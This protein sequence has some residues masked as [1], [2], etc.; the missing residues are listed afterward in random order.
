MK[1]PENFV[2]LVKITR[3]YKLKCLFDETIGV[4]LHILLDFGRTRPTLWAKMV[5]WACIML[6]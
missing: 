5:T 4:F 2:G 1:Y 3:N 6:R